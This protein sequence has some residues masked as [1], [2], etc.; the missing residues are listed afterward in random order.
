VDE[1]VKFQVMVDVLD[2]IRVSSE[3]A[4]K[5]SLEQQDKFM[6]QDGGDVKVAVT[7]KKRPVTVPVT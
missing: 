4:K 5:K 1:E 6:G 7:L 2:A 3:T